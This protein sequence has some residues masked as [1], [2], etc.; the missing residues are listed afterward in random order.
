M[1]QR[2][3]SSLRRTVDALPRADFEAIKSA[4]VSPMEKPDYITRQEEGRARRPVRRLVAMAACAV[5]LAAAV[6]GGSW[7]WQFAM[8]DAL[9]DIDVNP[10]Y[11]ITVNRRSQVLA[12]TPMNEEAK[13]VLEGRNYKGWDIEDAIFTLFS[14][15]PSHG[16]M[17]TGEPTVLVSVSGRNE[18]RATALREQVS[19]TIG[20]TLMGSPASPTVITQTYNHN[21]ALQKRAAEYGI[22]PGKMYIVDAL[23]EK[24]APYTEAQ[25]VAMP[26]EDLVALAY[27]YDLGGLRDQYYPSTAPSQPA[28]APA[29][30][31]SR[32]PAPSSTAAPASSAAPPP[33]PSAQPTPPAGNSPYDN[34]P[35]DDT[36]DDSPYE[37]PA[38]APAPAPA[39]PA[40][41][42]PHNDSPYDDTA[43]DSPYEEDNDDDDDD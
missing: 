33:T 41:D 21:N 9:V 15:L 24:G 39:P 43:D 11:D 4:S 32:P 22:S 35:Y 40:N 37:T 10:S 6:F 28:S 34:S 12:I 27:E 20:N 30:S 23:L 16:F 1:N 29:S 14:D 25:L 3:L 19:Q 8:V 31:S 36:A 2:I 42:S 26:I 17:D 7:Y 18:A 38:P 13:Q 5:C